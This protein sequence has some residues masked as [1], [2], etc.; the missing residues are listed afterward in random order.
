[1]YYK[2]VIQPKSNHFQIVLQFARNQIYQQTTIIIRQLSGKKRDRTKSKL[3]LIASRFPAGVL[4]QGCLVNV[5]PTLISHGGCKQGNS[6][7]SF[8]SKAWDCFGFYQPEEGPATKDKL[9]VSKAV[10]R[11]Y[12]KKYSKGYTTCFLH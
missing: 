7:L 2:M 1:M 9:D 4:S 12:K 3:I 10:C 5:L 11:L 8:W 6:Q